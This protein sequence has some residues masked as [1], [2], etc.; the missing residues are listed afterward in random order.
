[1][2]KPA[3]TPLQSINQFIWRHMSQANHRRM[4]GWTR[5]SVYVR[6]TVS[7]SSVFRARRKLLKDSADLQCCTTSEFQ[8]DT[9]LTLK[10]LADNA[11]VIR[12]TDSNSLSADHRVRD[13]W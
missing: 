8:T 2:L 10:A 1:M 5:P 6:Y 7:N 9:A 12:G 13:G 11:S 4:L 3:G